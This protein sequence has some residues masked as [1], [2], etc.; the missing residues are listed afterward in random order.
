MATRPTEENF[1]R[2]L[3]RKGRGVAAGISDAAGIA[4]DEAKSALKTVD[5]Q[6]EITVRTRALGSV[7]ENHAKQLDGQYK[8]TEQF[9]QVY[10][11]AEV[12][13]TDA[14]ANLATA[15]RESGLTA[16]VDKYV[17]TPVVSA[18]GECSEA[19]ARNEKL[20]EA[21]TFGA[22]FSQRAYSDLRQAIKPYF[23]AT[24]T[25]E[26][27]RNTKVELAYVS[28]CILQ[29]TSGESSVLAGQFSRALTAKL[30]GA[31]STAALLA[32]VGSVGSASTGTAIASLSGA[33][34]TKATLAWVGGMVGG[35]M[36]AG[37]V[38]TGGVGLVVVMAAYK[39]LQST[40]RPFES[41]SELEQRLVQSCWL[42]MAI[43]DSYLEKSLSDF[44]AKDARALLDESLRPLYVELSNHVD[45]LCAPLDAKNSMAFKHHV[46]VDFRRV[47]LN[48]FDDWLSDAAGLNLGQEAFESLL[49]GMFYALM[50]RHP[51]DDSLE[52]GLMLEALRRSTTRLASASEDELGDYLREHDEESLKKIAVNVKGIY[53]ELAWVEHYNATHTGT[54]ANVFEETNHPGADVEIRDSSS[55]EVIAEIQLKAVNTASHVHEAL[56]RFPDTPVY[57]TDETASAMGSEHVTSSGFSNDTISS[58]TD[59]DLTAVHDHTVANRAGQAGFLAF[60]VGS[61]REFLAMLQGKKAFP[62]AVLKTGTTVA[63]VTVT[64]ALTA[65]LFS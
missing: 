57:A 20:Q 50:T 55:H 18:A 24:N 27:L 37:T 31:G 1:F 64:T 32:L 22:A 59:Q 44:K 2:G 43:C 12:A 63:T 15:S 46:L 40:R 54:T 13:L 28:A 51:L 45:V 23:Q 35:G 38:I 48:G 16:A 47:V 53:H 11:A 3:Q 10:G 6:F 29:V 52:S 49:A 9:N 61:T 33:A 62:D 26:L 30:A 4:M 8:L 56:R 25:H 42:L 65:L 19:V 36:A 17:V 39:G 7:I 58:T 21:L 41:L 5:D 14:A 60:G 34:A